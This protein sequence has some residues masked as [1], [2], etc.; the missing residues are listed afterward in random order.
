[1]AVQGVWMMFMTRMMAVAHHDV[2]S[3]PQKAGNVTGTQISQT[4][5]PMRIVFI[6]VLRNL[7]LIWRSSATELP[8]ETLRPGRVSF[9]SARPHTPLLEQRPTRTGLATLFYCLSAV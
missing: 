8:F 3:Q 5:M 4:Q 6:C 7:Y 2:K 1:E 9:S